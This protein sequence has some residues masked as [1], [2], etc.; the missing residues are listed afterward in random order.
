MAR[1]FAMCG[2]LFSQRVACISGVA[3][4]MNWISANERLD[5]FGGRLGQKQ[6][7][8]YPLGCEFCY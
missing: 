3:I 2:L 6:T 5:N 4:G 8:R 7:S 1:M